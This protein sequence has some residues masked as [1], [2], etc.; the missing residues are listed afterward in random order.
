MIPW[1]PEHYEAFTKVKQIL[2]SEPVL[3]QPEI[4]REF[5]L[6]TDAPNVGIGGILLQMQEDNYFSIMYIS[7]K[8][9]ERGWNYSVIERECLAVVWAVEK[10]QN[11]NLYGREFVLL[12]DHE[13]LILIKHGCRMHE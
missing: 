2:S 4:G 6:R 9:L 7:K 11:K 8:L 1:G 12:E 10:V 13:T 5:A 3:K